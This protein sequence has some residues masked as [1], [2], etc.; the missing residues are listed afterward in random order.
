MWKKSLDL[1]IS[2]NI[3][4]LNW[5]ITENEEANLRLFSV[6][7]ENVDFQFLI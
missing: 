6:T 5:V 7:V 1:D 4:K 3:F 2:C